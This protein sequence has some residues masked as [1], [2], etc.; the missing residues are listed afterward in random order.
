MTFDAYFRLWLLIRH[1]HEERERDRM[2]R[3]LREYA[4]RTSA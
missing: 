3:E 4:T 2:A 1:M